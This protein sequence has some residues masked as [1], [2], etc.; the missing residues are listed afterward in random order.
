MT[1]SKPRLYL[2]LD[3]TVFDT[4][5]AI[6][7]WDELAKHYDLIPEA[8]VMD[9]DSYYSWPVPGTYYHDLSRQLEAYGIFPEEAYE[10]LRRSP[11]AD[12]RLQLPYTAQLVETLAPLTEMTVL[13]FG[14]DDY[15]RLKA[16]LCP[17][18]KNIPVVT[19][20]GDKRA[21]LETA[22]DCWLVDDKVPGAAP[23]DNVRFVQVA[24]PGAT[25]E[26]DKPWPLCSNLKEVKEYI[27]DAL[28]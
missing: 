22:G 1:S 12:G 15:Q 24:V 27:Y 3:R 23:P 18:L 14:A 11:L 5:R 2:D 25:V 21:V 17:A 7:L 9:R 16:D 10:L 8:C 20:L 26:A 28:H 19:T 6:L 4:D 13:T